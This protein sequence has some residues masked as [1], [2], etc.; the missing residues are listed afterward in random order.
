MAVVPEN[1]TEAAAA[2]QKMGESMHADDDTKVRD[3][4]KDC[5]WGSAPPNAAEELRREERNIRSQSG[6]TTALAMAKGAATG[7]PRLQS[8]NNRRREGE[9]PRRKA[10]E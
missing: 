8:A 6:G 3:H 5:P 7:N 2:G 1:V 10:K 4:E 9:E